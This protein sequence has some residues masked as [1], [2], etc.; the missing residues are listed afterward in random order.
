MSS[1]A[2]APRT[3]LV[4]GSGPLEDVIGFIE[5]AA[6]LE[7]ELVILS[8]GFPITEEQQTSVAAAIAMVAETHGGLD[9]VL[10]P[11]VQD[12]PR[13]LLPHD[14][15]AVFA[16]GI[17]RRTIEGTIRRAF[18]Q[19]SATGGASSSA[20]TATGP[21]FSSRATSAS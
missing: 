15:V 20:S 8:L 21:G 2:P 11:D 14:S 12:V 10:V 5:R 4:L 3:V 9:A 16:S 1:V 6:G 13:H 19:D 18:A 17:E 7:G